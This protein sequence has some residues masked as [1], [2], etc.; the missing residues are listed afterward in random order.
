MAV[1]TIGEIAPILAIALT[2]SSR[3]ST[4]QEFALLLV[5]L[6]MV[7]MAAA[8]GAG[9]RPPWVLALLERTMHAS[10]QMPVRFALLVMVAFAVVAKEFGFEGILGAFVAGMVV[11]LATRGPQSE[12]FFVKIDTVCLGWLMPFFFIGTGMNFDL[13]SLV[14]ETSTMLLAPAFML[15]FLLVRGLPVLLY[16]RDIPGPLQLPFALS[17]S[18]SSLG[19]IVVIT[20]IGLQT[21]VMN[22]D[23]AQALITAALLSLLVF[24]TAA[25]VL[26]ARNES[27]KS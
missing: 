14:R 5:F 13:G 20:Q 27:S 11:G 9:V 4:W 24:P 15:L 10:S 18:V 8:V 6:A 16:R 22:L 3:Y 2:L 1:G 12:L 17:S 21:Q 23:I 7:G 19:L 26:L 25:G